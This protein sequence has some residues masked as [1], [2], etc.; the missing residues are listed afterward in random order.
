MNRSS[1]QGGGAIDTVVRSIMPRSGPIVFSIPG[2]SGVEIAQAS[3]STQPTYGNVVF[4]Q[5]P[6]KYRV[7]DM[8]FYTPYYY[9]NAFAAID[10]QDHLGFS[11]CTDGFN[12]QQPATFVNALALNG[13]I[14]DKNRLFAQHTPLAL[15]RPFKLDRIVMPGQ[16]WR[17]QVQNSYADDPILPYLHFYVEEIVSGI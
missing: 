10:I 7:T 12:L 6:R 1:A 5:W 9:K 16:R 3:S 15:I 4:W 14:S 2:I 8:M 11:F 13:G 17:F